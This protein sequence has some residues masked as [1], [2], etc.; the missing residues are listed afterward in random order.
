MNNLLAFHVVSNLPPEETISVCR[1]LGPAWLGNSLF[2]LS[3]LLSGICQIRWWT[4]SLPVRDGFAQ[5]QSIISRSFQLKKDGALSM[6]LFLGGIF[7][8]NLKPAVHYSGVNVQIMKKRKG[9][10]RQ[11]PTIWKGSSIYIYLLSPPSNSIELK[12]HPFKM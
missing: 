12:D 6:Y 9:M 3:K 2:Q 10:K 11:Q 4:H 1:I 5:L 8:R 7:L